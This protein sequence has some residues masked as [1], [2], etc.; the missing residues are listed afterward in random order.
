MTMHRVNDGAPHGPEIGRSW[1][2]LTT[3][4]SRVAGMVV[5]GL[6]S[7]ALGGALTR[8][9]YAPLAGWD[10]AAIIF[11]AW[12]WVAIGT[13]TAARTAAHATR[14]DPGRTVT[15]LLVVVA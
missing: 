5:G 9:L 15:D 3:S 7:A 14:E 6:V 1:R 10:V 13:F 2:M 8:W 12:A 11:S 4:R